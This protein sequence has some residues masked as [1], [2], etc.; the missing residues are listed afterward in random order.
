M[1]VRELAELRFPTGYVFENGTLFYEKLGDDR[2]KGLLKALQ[3]Q[4]YRIVRERE[5]RGRRLEADAA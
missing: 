3:A 4:G 2:A 5:V 1:D